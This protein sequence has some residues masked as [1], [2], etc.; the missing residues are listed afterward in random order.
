MI[1][2]RKAR[3][4]LGT[5]QPSKATFFSIPHAL[6]CDHWNQDAFF[7]WQDTKRENRAYPEF[8]LHPNLAPQV[9]NDLFADRQTE[10]RTCDRLA[11]ATNERCE[12]SRV[13]LQGDAHAIVRDSDDPLWPAPLC[14]HVN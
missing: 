2:S 11:G 12:Y 3:L 13:V 1:R 5:V 14:G 9:F 10:T 6:G 8:G 4:S 7:R